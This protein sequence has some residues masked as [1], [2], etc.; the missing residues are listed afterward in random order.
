MRELE[1]AWQRD[2]TSNWDAT[3]TVQGVWEGDLARELVGTGNMDR[4]MDGWWGNWSAEI[5]TC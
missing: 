4:Q 2:G 5:N 1:L 3:D